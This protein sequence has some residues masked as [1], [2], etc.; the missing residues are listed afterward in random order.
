MARRLMMSAEGTAA[1]VA[2]L[3]ERAARDP[4]LTEPGAPEVWLTHVTHAL[5]A[6]ERWD[7]AERLLS[8]VIAN[9]ERAGAAFEFGIGSSL[10]GVIRHTRGDLIGA[11][12]DGSA[13]L[14]SG[15]VERFPFMALRPMID[16]YADQGL[17]PEGERLLAEHSFSGQIPD[18]R[19]L[20]PIL[21][22]RG[23]LRMAAGDLAGARADLELAL[24]RLAAGNN[25]GPAG[26]DARLALALVV[27]DAGQPDRA[28]GL[29]D[30]TLE[31]ARRWG[32]PRALGGALR[33][34]GLLRDDPSERLGLLGDA[35][36]A[37]EQSGALLWRAQALIDFGA[38][39]SA[40]G[41]RDRARAALA[42]GLDLADRAGAGPLVATAERELTRT[43]ARPRRR[44]L[45]G[46]DSLTPA[47]RRVAELAAGGMTNKTIAQ[48]LFVTLRTV[49]GHLTN[50]YR[51][52][53]IESRRELTAE[54]T[55][56]PSIR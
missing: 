37:L 5:T 23:K 48:T 15:G 35:V 50:A 18:A 10:R 1:E 39:L 56:P 34:A 41:E 19:P 40:A 27:A 21:I 29:S 55:Q 8:R 51:K 4:A 24:E 2:A 28:C 53:G 17:I 36:A 12:A 22:A 31:I 13:A 43:G 47:E 3:A 33:V 11:A 7:Q 44:A 45:A 42:E 52:L 54:L 38:N 14:E 20:T 25:R 6:A 32:A 30:H 9:A 49:E 26:L 16:A 46:I